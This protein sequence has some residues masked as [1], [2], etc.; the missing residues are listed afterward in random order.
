MRESF[1]GNHSNNLNNMSFNKDSRASY[2]EKLLVHTNRPDISG[3]GHIIK[4]E[5]DSD[6]ELVKKLTK[7][8]EQN[9][10]REV[11]KM[12]SLFEKFI[13]ESQSFGWFADCQLQLSSM[14][15]DYCNKTDI[16]AEWEINNGPM[17]HMA[18]AI[19]VTID[20]GERL[21]NKLQTFFDKIFK[22]QATELKYHR[23]LITK[24]EKHLT[25]IIPA[26]FGLSG[27]NATNLLS[28]F[29]NLKEL[30]MRSSLD[31]TEKQKLED[32]E[33][34]ITN[35][36]AQ[37]IFMEQILF[38]INTY[39]KNTTLN[40]VLLAEVEK[41]ENK[42]N[43]LLQNI[44]QKNII[45]PKLDEE[46]KNDT[47]YTTIKDFKPQKPLNLGSVQDGA[48]TVKTKYGGTN[49]VQVMKKPSRKTN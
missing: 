46:L 37:K 4:T 26:V 17:G 2:L 31:E 6:S 18:L 41:I 39:K 15:D 29:A 23:S 43:T 49:I 33:N 36:P 19:D 14:Y 45:Y 7:E 48:H 32:L 47:C 11:E 20:T 13:I 12:S 27:G 25:N 1:T 24:E 40:P 3:F 35:H 38:Q 22:N 9:N 21:T 34:K 10:D 16:V 8:Y 44:N 30:Q 28:D 42:I 5:R